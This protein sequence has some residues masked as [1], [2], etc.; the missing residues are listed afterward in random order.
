MVVL[1][2]F[3]SLFVVVEVLLV[4]FDVLLVVF[5]TLLVVFVTLLNGIGF[6]LGSWICW[7]LPPLHI[8]EAS[9]VPPLSV[10]NVPRSPLRNKEFGT[11]VLGPTVSP[12]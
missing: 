5:V 3:D 2:V 1:V 11:K 8:P 9:N 7:P 4:V 12:C 10:H 6:M